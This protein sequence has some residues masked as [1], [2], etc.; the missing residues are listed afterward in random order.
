MGNRPPMA[1]SH[2]A[3]LARLKH[4]HALEGVYLAGGTA[5]AWHLGHRTSL[6]LDL[7]GYPGGPDLDR[8]L[9]LVQAMPDARVLGRSDATL[10]FQLAGLPIDVVRYPY[11]PLD[12]P[13]PTSEGFSVAS[14]RDLAADKVSTIARRGLRRDFWD[15]HAMAQ[16]G[17]RL[18]DALQA[19]RERFGTSASDLYH[20]VRAQTYFDDAECETVMPAGMTEALWETVKTFFVANAPSLVRLAR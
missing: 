18:V 12:P 8:L 17:L 3:A 9:D 16:S 6:D 13:T 1:D 11:A 4:A 15:L 20:V 10:R 19:Y 5:V 7:F 2:R 14:L